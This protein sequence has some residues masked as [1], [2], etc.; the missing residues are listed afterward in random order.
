[1]REKN[2]IF[3]VPTVITAVAI[4]ATIFG[5]LGQLDWKVYDFMLHARASPQEERSVLLT[6]L[7]DAAIA[8]IG[9]WPVGR[10]VV[11]DGLAALADLGARAITFDIEY[12]DASPRG[13]DVRY[14]EEDIP[15][16]FAEGFGSLSGNIRGLF[17]ALAKKQIP[18][19]AAED[20]VQDL[21]GLTGAVRDE[22]LSRVRKIAADNDDRLGKAA[23]FFGDAYFTVNMR[24]APEPNQDSAIVAM[25]TAKAGKPFD[26]AGAGILETAQ[27]ILP[28]ISPILERGA[29]AGFPNVWVDPDGVRRRIDLF[30]EY[31]GKIYAQLVM[32]PLLD[33]LGSPHVVVN[34]GSFEL[35]G[36]KLPSGEE[37]NI[38]VPRAED[39]RV[40]IDWPHKEYLESFRHVSFREYILHEK[41]FADLAHNLR[42]RDSWGYFSAYHGEESLAS[43][44]LR[45]EAFRKAC[46][47]EDEAP[48]EDAKA[49]LRALRDGLLAECRAFLATEPEKAIAEDIE[50]LLASKKLDA[51]SRAQ[52]EQIKADAPVYFAA[53]RTLVNDIS[54]F[55]ERLKKETQDAFCII[56]FTATGT[57]DIGV[58]PFAGE[59]VNVG[60]HAAVYNT[61][62][63]R[64]FL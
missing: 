25:A 39:G 6:D 27:G 30:Y 47:T 29:G 31:D 42:I 33:I 22:L 9:T 60:T 53:T 63:R 2:Q 40:L 51:A 38:H 58:N 11:A 15:D 19:S 34:K 36:A 3:I 50:A 64:S 23:R 16:S 46:L 43:L 4:L 20:Y 37:T 28:T 35:I 10:D 17:T 8:E 48:P 14:L 62:L 24:R 18:L 52:Y 44:A 59:Y 5:L 26:K 57:T 1:M 45:T 54:D 7:D 12:V 32:A 56:G 55:R 61:V 13:V 41:M 49:S 21:E